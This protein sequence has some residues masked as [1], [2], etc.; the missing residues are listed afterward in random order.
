V[1]TLGT[2]AATVLALTFGGCTVTDGGTRSQEREAIQDVVGEGDLTI[3]LS[4]PPTRADLAMPEGRST[5][6]LE[7]DDDE[8]FDV[9]VVFRD[10]TEL[11]TPARWVSVTAE[12]G[13]ADPTSVT[14][15]RAGDGL[16]DLRAAVEQSVAELG[17]E[18]ARADTALSQSEQATSGRSDVM[19][20][21]PTTIAPPDKLTVRTIA[22]ASREEYA[23]N[24]IV[25]WEAAS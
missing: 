25:E 23:V 13:D 21:L 16:D 19:Y 11:T 17:V 18:Q 3:D 4:S 9:R 7:R 1:R 5:V 15:R 22:K 8:P 10:G 20:A 24:Y 2:V 6:I 14:I 12:D